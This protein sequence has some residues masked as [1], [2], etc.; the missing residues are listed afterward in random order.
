MDLDT[1][2]HLIEESAAVTVDQDER[3]AWLTDRLA[4]MPEPEIEDFQIHLDVV[5]QRVD[6]WHMWGA[7]DRIRHGLCSDDGFWYF[8]CWLVGLGRAQF[9][10]VA[11]DPDAL[12]EVA[13]VRQL[14]GR[15]P[16]DWS[17]DDWPN[18]ELLDVVADEAYERVTGREDA[19]DD[20]LESRGHH[21]R[22]SSPDPQDEQWNFRDQDEMAR[23]YPR[24]SRMFLASGH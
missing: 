5:R 15:R 7:A 2:W 21:L 20:A 22:Q 17:D 1:F 18:W 24:L 16:S 4:R 14:A 8:Q 19:L 6:T 12:A 9:E 13:P 23:R 3:S 11:A 10:R